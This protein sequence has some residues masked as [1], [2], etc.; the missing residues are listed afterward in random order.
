MGALG[1]LNPGLLAE[2]STESNIRG[3]TDGNRE[4]DLTLDI[5]SRWF[6]VD[7]PDAWVMFKLKM[8]L[9][10]IGMSQ[11]W[12]LHPVVSGDED[13]CFSRGS[14]PIWDFSPGKIQE[15]GFWFNLQTQQNT[16]DVAPFLYKLSRFDS[17]FDP[18]HFVHGYPMI[19]GLQGLHETVHHVE[20]H[21]VVCWFG[22]LALQ[23]VT[24]WQVDCPAC[25]KSS[26]NLSRGS[27]FF[28][29]IPRKHF[30][31]KSTAHDKGRF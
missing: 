16:T 22:W 25:S 10:K 31:K 9:L 29:R 21:P 30:N 11:K 18:C 6:F 20:R 27:H 15:I 7:F 12:L 2:H 17:M 4:P 5:T 13:A 3:W 1:V 28:V 8:Y 14:R 24:S 26:I 19:S 23:L